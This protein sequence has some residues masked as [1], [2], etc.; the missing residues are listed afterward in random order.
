MSKKIQQL[1]DLQHFVQN[2]K[3]QAV[4]ED[5]M[6]RYSEQPCYELEEEEL[7]ML[8]AAGDAE[9]AGS[10]NAELFHCCKEITQ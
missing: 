3:L 7:G 9:T 10:N 4:I 2:E 5:T 1:F 8:F 6:R